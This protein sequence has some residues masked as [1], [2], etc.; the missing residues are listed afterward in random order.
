MNVIGAERTRYGWT[1]KEVGEMVGVAAS[2][3]RAWENDIGS[4][5]ASQ[6]IALSNI[7]GGVSVDYLLGIEEERRVRR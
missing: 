3:V 7:F 5:K 6:L 1:Q 2:T 4:C